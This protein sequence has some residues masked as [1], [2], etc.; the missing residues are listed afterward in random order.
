[1]EYG[2][3]KIAWLKDLQKN[4]I[5]I[6]WDMLRK[7][8]EVTTAISREKELKKWR[9]KKKNQLIEQLNPSLGDLNLQW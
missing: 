3:T 1:M 5:S 7:S 8:S 9:R 2:N 6:K 4:K